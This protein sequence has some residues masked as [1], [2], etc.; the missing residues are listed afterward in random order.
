M[1]WGLFWSLQADGFD[2]GESSAEPPHLANISVSVRALTGTNR[3]L[4]TQATPAVG[5]CTKA[6]VLQL[7]ACDEVFFID[8]FFFYPVDARGHKQFT[9]THKRNY[10]QIKKTPPLGI[11]T[12]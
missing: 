5:E 6:V 2:S 9:H 7:I 8:L 3:L 12:A 1:L 11:N 10:F 4:M